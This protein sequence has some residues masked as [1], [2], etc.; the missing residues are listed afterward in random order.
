MKQLYEIK[1]FDW[2]GGF[3]DRPDYDESSNM[4]VDKILLDKFITLYVDTT[5]PGPY[6]Q[7]FELNRMGKLKYGMDYVIYEKI[8]ITTTLEDLE[9][10]QDLIDSTNKS[11]AADKTPY[12]NHMWYNIVTEMNNVVN[13]LVSSLLEA[14]NELDDIKIEVDNDDPK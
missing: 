4:L 10:T 1:F 12:L 5:K 11:L 13:G 9:P 3:S 14:L 2:I 6:Y 8:T 7:G